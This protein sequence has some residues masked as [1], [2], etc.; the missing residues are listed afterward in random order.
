[1]SIPYTTKWHSHRS[2]KT[3]TSTRTEA[4]IVADG[5]HYLVG[6]VFIGHTVDDKFRAL[7]VRT[8]K[9]LWK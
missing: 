7:D 5:P 9:V 4:I 6:L 3:H 2:W 8:D 1:M